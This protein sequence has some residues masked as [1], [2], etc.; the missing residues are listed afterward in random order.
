VQAPGASGSN[1]T[2]TT[3]TPAALRDL[4]IRANALAHCGRIGD[5]VSVMAAVR[6][7]SAETLPSHPFA[8]A[9]S[10]IAIQSDGDA[11]AAHRHLM[12]ALEECDV[13]EDMR[14]FNEIFG[15]LMVTAH[16]RGNPEWW[17]EAQALGSEHRDDLDAVN[18]FTLDSYPH[19]DPNKWA[20]PSSR[21]REVESSALAGPAWKNTTLTVATANLN[22]RT[23]E[24]TLLDELLTRLNPTEHGLSSLAVQFAFSRRNTGK[25]AERGRQARELLD[26]ISGSAMPYLEARLQGFIS[27]AYAYLGDV[28]ASTEHAELALAWAEPRGL[29]LVVEDVWHARTVLALAESDFDTA[30]AI[31]SVI[32]ME[33]HRWEI[34]SHGA[35]E[36]FNLAEAC[37]GVSRP[38]DAVPAVFAA[39]AHRLDSQT[40]RQ[41]MA[42]RT[43]Q[44]ILE[45]DNAAADRMFVS[46]LELEPVAN[47]LFDVARVRLA[48]GGF[49]IQR[50]GDLVKGRDQ[51]LRAIAAFQSVG[52]VGWAERAERELSSP[53]HASTSARP[54]PKL[55]P[56]E[57]LVA[58]YAAQGL[59]NKEIA[60]RLFISSRT[61]SYHLYNLFPKLGISSRA[62][63]RDALTTLDDGE[64]RTA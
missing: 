53:R 41:A 60:A 38:Q 35:A 11:E 26:T 31:L 58:S 62:A 19:G 44:A 57:H 16:I 64:Q 24:T 29:R 59:S 22:W 8:A 40:P 39:V 32:P 28:A 14:T 15:M 12:S 46:A 7:A 23:D 13:F 55:S 10:Y 56:Q 18:A 42:L 2:A 33:A 34:S 27:V 5:A 9:K 20:K 43:A 21:W 52:A 36:I 45:P 4:G 50:Q 49:L 48:Y 61:V 1:Q 25:W 47:S 6:P 17:R 37:N 51:M 54:R 30:H 3:P 63:L